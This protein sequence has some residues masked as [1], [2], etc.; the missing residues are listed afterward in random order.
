MINSIFF[1]HVDNVYRLVTE[2]DRVIC[3]PKYG[4]LFAFTFDN[5]LF[6]LYGSHFRK[7]GFE[8]AKMKIKITENIDL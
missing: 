4:S 2:T 3:V 7:H 5:M 8:R 6:K 1:F